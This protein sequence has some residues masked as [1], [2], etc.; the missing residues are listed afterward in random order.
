[1][2]FNFLVDVSDLDFEEIW[3]NMVICPFRW[4]SC[5]AEFSS[6]IFVYKIVR[7]RNIDNE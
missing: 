5:Y 2:F 4:R 1:M 6:A 7:G 3:L